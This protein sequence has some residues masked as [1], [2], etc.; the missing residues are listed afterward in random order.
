MSG[1]DEIAG[2]TVGVVHRNDVFEYCQETH[3]IRHVPSNDECTFDDVV[4]A[5]AVAQLRSGPTSVF[6]SRGALD[7]AAETAPTVWSRYPYECARKSARRK[8]Y[9]ELDRLKS[10]SDEPPR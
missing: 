3:T 2:I 9:E 5:Y 8:L 7:K 4:G 10:T 1:R 6:L